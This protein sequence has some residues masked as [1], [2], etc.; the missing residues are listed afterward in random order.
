MKIHLLS[1]L[2]LEYSLMNVGLSSVESD[3][4]VL[5]GDIH[6]GSMGIG[7]AAKTWKD[8]PVIYGPGNHEYYNRTYSQHRMAM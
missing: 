6:S 7:W 3:V 5:A 4:V 8:R 2:H 1:D